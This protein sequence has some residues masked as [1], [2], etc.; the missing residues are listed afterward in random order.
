M[1][2]ELD[3]LK[4]K[5]KSDLAE[6][7]AKYDTTIVQLEADLADARKGFDHER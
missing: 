5:A 6:M 1:E 7:K 3:D 2:R 4:R